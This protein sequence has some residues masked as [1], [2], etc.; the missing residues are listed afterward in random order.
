MPLDDGYVID[1]SERTCSDFAADAGCIASVPTRVVRDSKR[2]SGLTLIRK[3]PSY[4][5]VVSG[6]RPGFRLISY[7]DIIFYYVNHLMFLE[8]S[9]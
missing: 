7:L 2:L 9:I 5:D 3:S 4:F 8:S 1:W 6:L